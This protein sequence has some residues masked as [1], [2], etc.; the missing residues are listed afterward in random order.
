MNKQ[1]SEYIKEWSQKL[2]IPEKDIDRDF[3]T[4]LTEEN[5]IHKDLSEDDRKQRALKRLALLYKKQLKSPA[6]GFEG[7]V[8]GLGDCNDIVAK[9]KREAIELFK[10]DP[11]Q[12][13]SQGFVDENGVPLNTL[14]VF[15]DGRKNPGFGKPL[16]EH[17]YLR[18]V[19][20]IAIKSNVV[21]DEPKF[22]SMG[23]SGEKAQSD[24]IPMFTPVRFMAIDKTPKETEDVMYVLNQSSFTSINEDKDLKLPE[25]EGLLK[26]T[27][28]FT[29]IK[30]LLDFHNANKDNFNRVVIT[31]GSVSSLKLEPTS[32]GSRVITIEDE[33]LALEDIEAHSGVTC[34]V[35]LR[36]NIDFAEGSKILVVGR[37]SQGNKKD[38]AGNKT[39]EL[40]DVTINVYGLYAL[41]DFKIELP[42]LEVLTEADI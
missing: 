10:K 17:N 22:F 16:P 15:K 13:V 24:N 31:E 40:G 8:I 29:E 37:T 6:V 2:S 14:S 42:E 18:N 41:P 12:A 1:L 28:Y 5:E 4:F 34:W 27:P 39:E 36:T 33:D 30:D 11:Q 21:N 25:F 38:D 32:V 7:I 23:F 9:Q 35:P 20:G 26:A 3:Q 19:Y